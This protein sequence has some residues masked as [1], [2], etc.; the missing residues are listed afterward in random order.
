MSDKQQKRL[1]QVIAIEKQIKTRV[2]SEGS[3]LHKANQKPDLFNG[4]VRVYEKKDEEGEDLPGESKLVQLRAEEQLAQWGELWSEL[5]NVV[6]T[7]DTGNTK[8]MADIVVDDQT[9]ATNVPVTSLIW[10]EKQLDDYRSFVDKLPVLDPSK[11]WKFHEGLNLHV[12][13]PAKTSRNKKVVRV[14]TK[15]EATDRHP[16]QTELVSDDVI[17]GYWS[18][19]NTSGAMSS[20]RK[21]QLLDR[22]DALRKAVKQAREEANS[23]RIEN[24]ELGKTLQSWLLK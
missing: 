24:V 22:V 5:V 23:I 13:E 16:A 20:T 17:A 19:T 4:L 15:A 9:V 1:N 8:A 18:N 11:A 21:K 10:L 6:S 7:K 3:E 12:T 2:N 14:I